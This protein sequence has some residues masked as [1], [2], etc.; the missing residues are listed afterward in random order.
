MLKVIR[1]EPGCAPAAWAVLAQ[2]DCHEDTISMHVSWPMR[3]QFQADA[4]SGFRWISTFQCRI[5]LH[6]LLTPKN[7]SF[8]IL[9]P[10]PYLHLNVASACAVAAE[11]FSTI[12]DEFRPLKNSHPFN[13]ER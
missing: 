5:F 6:I 2:S 8:K 1:I 12:V 3:A 4:D 10:S 9:Y 13:N 11:N 7:A